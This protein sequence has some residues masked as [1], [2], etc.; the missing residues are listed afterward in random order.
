[1]QVL[2]NNLQ[3]KMSNYID[4]IVIGTE[5]FK[6]HIRMLQI[7]LKIIIENKLTSNLKKCEFFKIKISFL[8]FE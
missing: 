6:G 4:D 5:T 7:I 1:M 2:L 8:G 3:T